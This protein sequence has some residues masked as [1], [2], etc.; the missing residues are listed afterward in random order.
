M[1][2]FIALVC[3][4]TGM[5]DKWQDMRDPHDFGDVNEAGKPLLS[6]IHQ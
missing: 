5:D 3:S 6:S 2:D 1:G 4:W